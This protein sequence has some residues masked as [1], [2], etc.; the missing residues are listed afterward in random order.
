VLTSARA[1]N[2]NRGSS[3]SRL[4]PFLPVSLP[5]YFASE[6]S[7]AQYRLPSASGTGS[8]GGGVGGNGAFENEERCVIVWA[9][10]PATV[11]TPSN[12]S[13]STNTTP[14]HW[15]QQKPT[16][17]PVRD[18][19]PSSVSPTSATKPPSTTTTSTSTDPPEHQL[20]AL[21][22]SGGWYRIA[23]PGSTSSAATTPSS[24]SKRDRHR[25]SSVSSSTTQDDGN[26]EAGTSAATGKSF[27]N[28][29]LCK[30]VEY[31]RFGEGAGF[32]S[33]GGVETSGD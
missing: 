9:E 16:A 3:F 23:L 6:W 27:S 28:G 22:Y 7:H 13:T 33:G 30:L 25:R 21:T 4:K 24:T 31:R 1:P 8:G 10:V 20:I 5:K 32:G 12:S 19:S 17:T 26:A 14:S 18:Y 29:P 15:R 2:R 11:G